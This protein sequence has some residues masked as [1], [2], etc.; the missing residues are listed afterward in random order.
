MC[1]HIYTQ[2]LYSIATFLMACKAHP[3]TVGWTNLTNEQAEELGVT[4]YCVTKYDQ[5]WAAKDTEGYWDHAYDIQAKLEELYHKGYNI[6]NRGEVDH[7]DYKEG[8]FFDY[9]E[10]FADW[11]L[12]T[13]PFVRFLWI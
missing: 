13:A 11:Y 3:R 2:L 8:S 4:E 12:E 1:Y 6:K 10:A 9:D 7:P 5:K